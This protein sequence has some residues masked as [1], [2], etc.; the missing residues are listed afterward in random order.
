MAKFYS[1]LTPELISFIEEQK[2]IIGNKKILIQGYFILGKC[3]QAKA[4]SY[5]NEACLR[6]L[7]Y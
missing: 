7:K 5:T 4:W 1:E 3:S 2:M 6:R